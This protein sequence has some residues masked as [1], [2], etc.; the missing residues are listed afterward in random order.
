[1]KGPS[2][3]S[4]PSHPVT[5]AP[6]TRTCPVSLRQLLLT[7]HGS[8]S[9]TDLQRCFKLNDYDSMTTQV[10]THLDFSSF[11]CL[12]KL[13]VNI[14]NMQG[15]VSMSFTGSLNEYCAKTK[16]LPSWKT[17]SFRISSTNDKEVLIE[18]VAVCPI[19]PLKIRQRIKKYLQWYWPDFH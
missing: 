13:R 9:T 19:T 1:M 11:A 8:P 15:W 14:S 3:T 17:Q 2:T 16:M 4:C 12:M 7:Q 6:S 18:A 5:T 10:L